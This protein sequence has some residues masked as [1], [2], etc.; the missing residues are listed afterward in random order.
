M[1]ISVLKKRLRF[2]LR[3]FAD[4][5]ERRRRGRKKISAEGLPLEGVR[6]LDLTHVW[7]GPHT[8]RL[9]AD[10]GAE[11]IKVEYAKRL[12]VARGSQSKFKLYN[13]MPHILQLGR[14]K[15]SITLD[16]KDPRGKEI[17]TDL[18]KV[19]DVVLENFRAGFMKR[20]ELDYGNLKEFRT[21]I[22]HVSMPGFGSTGPQA[23]YPSYGASLEALSGVQSLT[24]YEKGTRSYRAKELDMFIGVQGASAIMTAL[25]YRQRTGEGQWLDLSQLEAAAT[26]L[27]GEHLLEFEMNGHQTFPLGNRHPVFAPHGCYRSKGEDKWIVIA[28]RTD[29]EWGHL[30]EAVG[31]PEWKGDE[32]F[33]SAA[34]RMSHHDDLDRLLESWTSERSHIEATHTLQ[35]AGVPAGAV[36]NMKE[37][38]CDRHVIAR[39]FIRTARNSGERGLD[40]PGVPF[41][42][43]GRSG[44]IFWRGPR[45]GEDNAY[46]ICEVLGRSK[47]DLHSLRSDRVGTAFDIEKGTG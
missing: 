2:I 20:V 42:F 37:L 25:L 35:E 41:K 27:I 34:K 31:H 26:G 21:D 14:N 30:C 1:N 47:S 15:R 9:L 36:L 6:V 8:G 39:G 40:F 5:I 22:I 13:I 18:V 16:L 11:V 19:S 24:A 3:V 33:S 28:V 44:D 7:S 32:R 45:L 4:N 38:C 29:E 43:S 17:F 23:S 10:W 46:V 12:D